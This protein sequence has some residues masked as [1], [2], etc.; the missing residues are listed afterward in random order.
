MDAPTRKAALE[1]LASFDPRLGH[2]VKYIDYSTLA[3]R[4]RRP[5]RQCD[6]GPS[7]STG[8]CSS[9]A[10]PKP[11]DR[12]AVGHAAADQQRLL[13]PVEEPDHLPG[14]DPAA[15]L[16]RSRTPIR[17]SNYGSIGATIGHEIGPRL[18]RPG[19]P[20]TIRKGKLRDWWTPASRQGLHRAHGRAGQAVR[21]LRADPGRAHQ[22]PADA[23]REPRRS[24]RPR[25]RLRRLP[26]LRRQARRAAGD[27]RP[28]RRPALLHRLRLQLGDQG[29]RRRAALAAAQRPAQPGRSIRVNGV[30]RNVDAWY[31]AFNV[32]PGDKLYLPPDQRVHIW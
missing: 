15:A 12:G 8:T 22:G 9:R 26:P 5:V 31:K 25:S 11:V 4:S 21:Q 32:Q 18:R 13:R 19:P 23:R 10:I 30:V 17:P 1:K 2:P 20:V 14:R 3:G 27:R 29:A 28:H 24:R 7:S 6:R 16:F